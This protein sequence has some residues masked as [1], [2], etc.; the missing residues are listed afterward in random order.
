MELKMIYIRPEVQMFLLG[1]SYFLCESFVA[2]AED[3][4]MEDLI[5]DDFEW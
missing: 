3:Q 2:P 5:I 4:Q 1:Q